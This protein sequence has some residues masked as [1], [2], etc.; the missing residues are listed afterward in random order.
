M[1]SYSIARTIQIFIFSVTLALSGL[2]S[3][4]PS[5]NDINQTLKSGDI[6]KADELMKEVISA[7]PDSAK[8]H[9][10]YAEILAAQGKLDDARTELASAERLQPN[11]A[12][13]K[14]AAV[15]ALKQKINHADQGGYHSTNP[16]VTWGAVAF[17]VFFIVFIVRSISRR[18]QIQSNPLTQTNSYGPQTSYQNTPQQGGGMGSNIASSLATGAAI[19]AGVVAGEMLMH[20]VLDTNQSSDHDEQTRNHSTPSN[21]DDISGNDFVDSDNGSWDSDSGSDFSS[22]SDSGGDW[23]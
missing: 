17:V 3:A 9:F 23:S 16:L 19:G 2:V 18:P 21:Y 1:Q 11:L 8:A 6:S 14:P 5:L 7:H 4:E 12:F 15:E 10:K 20:K 22:D 13:A